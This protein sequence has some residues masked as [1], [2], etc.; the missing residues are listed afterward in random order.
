MLRKC[1]KIKEDEDK[2]L[3]QEFLDDV[4]SNTPNEEQFDEEEKKKQ[5]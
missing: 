5:K 2:E 3:D 1:D 4:A